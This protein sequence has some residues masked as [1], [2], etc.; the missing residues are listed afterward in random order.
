LLENIKLNDILYS[1]YVEWEDSILTNDIN[2]F[3]NL[4]EI[5]IIANKLREYDIYILANFIGGSS[6]ID[7]L[8]NSIEFITEFVNDYGKEKL[9][10]K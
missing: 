8:Y 3:K 6:I 5:K 7:R 1:E 10:V 2:L 4:K 9:K